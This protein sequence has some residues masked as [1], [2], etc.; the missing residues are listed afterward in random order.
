M[1]KNLRSL[2]QRQPASNLAEEFVYYQDGDELDGEA[3]PESKEPSVE[4]PSVPSELTNNEEIPEI[5]F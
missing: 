5:L 1:D 2:R 3:P 4:E